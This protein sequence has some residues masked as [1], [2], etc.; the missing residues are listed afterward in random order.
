[1]ARPSKAISKLAEFK[2]LEELGRVRLSPNFFMR[3]FLHSEISQIECTPNIPHHPEIAIKYGTLL[4]ERVIEPIQEHFGRISIRS[5]YRS[6]E[7]N[8]LGATNRNQYKCASNE[9]NFS[10]HIWDYPDANG[11]FGAMA[12][13]VVC[14]Y[15]EHYQKTGDWKTLAQWIHKNVDGYSIMTFYPKLCAFNISWHE[16]PQKQISSYIRPQSFML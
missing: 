7:V 13:I 3:E 5:G 10:H 11:Y 2:R 16:H 1:M 14:S 6:P 4:C 12:C 15:V 9:H 8:A